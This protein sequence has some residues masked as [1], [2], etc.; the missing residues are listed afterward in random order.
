VAGLVIAAEGPQATDRKRWEFWKA[1]RADHPIH[2]RLV[3]H[4]VVRRNG[5]PR[6]TD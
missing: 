3:D 1:D 4:F 6:D 2:A 5:P